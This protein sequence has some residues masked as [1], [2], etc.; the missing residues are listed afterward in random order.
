[1]K[2]L[3]N[4]STAGPSSGDPVE[5]Q[6]TSVSSWLAIFGAVFVQLVMSCAC[7]YLYS[8]L[9]PVTFGLL[10]LAIIPYSRPKCRTVVGILGIAVAFLLFSKN[11]ADILWLGHE[12][13]FGPI[14]SR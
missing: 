5:Y 12:P 1:M 8:K 2:D 11:V 3:K 7:G 9:L 10:V 6:E 13:L 4:S 14:G